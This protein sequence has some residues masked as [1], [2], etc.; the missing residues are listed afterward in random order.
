MLALRLGVLDDAGTALKTVQPHAKT[1]VADAR[2][3]P[4]VC[5]LRCLAVDDGTAP[6]QLT[7]Q[8]PERVASVS[9][10]DGQTSLNLA[11]GDSVRLSE[12]RELQ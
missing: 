2:S 8:L 9:F 7:V 12:I 10:E 5:F 1:V 4:D 11:G 3:R 6:T